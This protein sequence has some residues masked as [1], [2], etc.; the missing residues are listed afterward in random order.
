MGCRVQRGQ[1]LLTCASERAR[2]AR[3]TSRLA[4]PC[5]HLSSADSVWAGPGHKATVTVNIR[6]FYRIL[7]SLSTLSQDMLLCKC[8]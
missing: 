8:A 4:I 1:Q 2:A 3:L 5:C 7:R 6:E